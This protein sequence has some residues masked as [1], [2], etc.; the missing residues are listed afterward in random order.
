MRTVAASA[1]IHVSLLFQNKRIKK[2]TG[3]Y[4]N[5]NKVHE[6]VIDPEIDELRPEVAY[7]VIIVFEH[8]RRIVQHI[9]IKLSH[10][11]DG[12]ERVPQRV[13]AHNQACY[14]K[15][16][17][18]PKDLLHR[19]VISSNPKCLRSGRTTRTAVSVSMQRT[20]GSRVKYRES[21][22]AYSFHSCAKRVCM[23]ASSLLLYAR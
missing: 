21:A 2:H 6:K 23:P 3:R 4:N 9:S 16:Q 13:V 10:G 11:D 15:A 22:S 8:A 1:C 17:R 7:L 5:P 19:H 12:L 14:D 20:K 18:T